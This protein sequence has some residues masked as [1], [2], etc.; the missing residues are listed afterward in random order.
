MAEARSKG[1]PTWDDVMDIMNDTEAKLQAARDGGMDPNSDEYKAIEEEG[2]SKAMA[3]IE[4][5]NKFIRYHFQDNAIYCDKTFDNG[6]FSTSCTDSLGMYLKVKVDGSNDRMVVT[7]NQ[8]NTVTITP[9][10]GLSI[11]NMARDYELA[12]GNKISTSSFAVVHEIAST[13]NYQTKGQSGNGRYDVS[14]ASDGAAKRN[15]AKYK[16][17]YKKAYG[18]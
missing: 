17:W 16:K 14:F 8:N 1:L 5:I 10:D 4:V 3:R 13:L 2:K 15:L 6:S 18:K 7:D 11:N 12:S 9:N